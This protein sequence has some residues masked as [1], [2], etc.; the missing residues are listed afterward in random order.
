[1]SL[2]ERNILVVE[3]DLIIALHLEQ[4][5]AEAG[6]YPI[7]PASTVS[8]ALRLLNTERVDG[9]ILDIDLH[10]EVATFVVDALLDRGVPFVFHTGAGVPLEL[11]QRC[12]DVPVHTKPV[13]PQALVTSLASL[14]ARV[15]RSAAA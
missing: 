5:I 15:G 1:M 6:G 12:P 4:T 8:D 3:D 10:H 11:Q 9:A 2:Q 7:G 14:F 13:A